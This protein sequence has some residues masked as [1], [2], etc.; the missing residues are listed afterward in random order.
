VKLQI[1]VCHVEAGIRLGTLSN[2][3]EVNRICTDHVSDLLLFCTNSAKVS[4]ASEGLL[5]KAQWLG[6]PIYDTFIYFGNGVS[7][8]NT[9]DI[10][11]L[12]GEPVA[13]G[14]DFY[15]L[16]CHRQENTNTEQNLVEI[17]TAMNNLD[18]PTVYP[19]HPRTQKM[20]IRLK[21]RFRN[22][23]FIK[24][25][26]LALVKSARKIVIDS[27]GLQREAFFAEKQCVFV[28]DRVAWPETMVGNRNQL[29]SPSA[30]DIMEK[31]STSQYVDPT[32]RPFG[33]GHAGEQIA[34]AIV[35]WEGRT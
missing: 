24:H 33:E 25:T 32:Y 2:P 9:A 4:L 10:V 29:A 5:E 16:T 19:V 20:A 21:D 3:G 13:I 34:K 22:V 12:E 23:H 28:F 27:G 1:P 35:A 17:L 11:T 30:D 26:S 14:D 6:D 7:R 31:L 15:Y 8:L 18:A